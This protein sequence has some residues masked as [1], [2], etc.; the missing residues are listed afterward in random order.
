MGSAT[1]WKQEK[2]KSENLKID[3]QNLLSLIAEG[4]LK[5][6]SINFQGYVQ[7]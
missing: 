2:I 5:N 1:E 7:E 6:T 3:Q 4:K